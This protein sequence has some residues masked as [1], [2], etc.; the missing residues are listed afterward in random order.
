M[1]SNSSLDLLTCVHFDIVGSCQLRC[2]GCPNSTIRKNVTRIDPQLFA[3]CISNIDV[4]RVNTF[5]FFN[6]GEPLLHTELPSIFDTFESARAFEVDHAELSTNAQFVRWDQLEYVISRRVL[7]RLVVSCDGDGTPASYERMRPP[8]VW[9][10]LIEFLTRARQLR[11]RYAPDLDLMTR[12]VVFGAADMERWRSVLNPIGWRPEFRP[13]FPL[14]G[15]AENLSGRNIELGQ[16]VCVFMSE[17]HLYVDVD[18]TVVPCCAHPRAGELGSL[19]Y[20]R[21]SEIFSGETRRRFLEVLQESR[22]SLSVCRGC[23]FGANTDMSRYTFERP[24]S[25]LV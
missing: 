14:V 2:V 25:N 3:R 13:F 6:Y 5:R 8:A 18:G 24:S 21:Y 23:E 11:D 4:R 22:D 7:H 1:K 10:K 20:H 15:G 17:P 16:G 12:T 19:K 9:S